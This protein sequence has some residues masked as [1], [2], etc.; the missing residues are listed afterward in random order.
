MSRFV[1]LNATAFV[2]TIAFTGTTLSQDV[3]NGCYHKTNGKLRIV[4]DPS[5]CKKKEIPI[6]WN[7]V[8]VQ[9]PKGDQ[10]DPGL[11]GPSG[12]QGPQGEQGP[13]GVQGPAGPSGNDGP[14]GTPGPPGQ[15]GDPGEPG[16]S[17]VGVLGVYDGN[18]IL[19]GYFVQ[20]S[21]RRALGYEVFDPS[22]PGFFTMRMTE[23]RPWP[24]ASSIGRF[25]YTSDNCDGQPHHYT[26][27]G[28]IE[29]GIHELLI[30]WAGEGF[31]VVDTS[32]QFPRLSDIK[33]Q[34]EGGT[35]ECVPTTTLVDPSS[36]VFP[37]KNI[38]RPQ[39]M[40]QTFSYPLII[41]P[42]D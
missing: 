11:E 6:V 7:Q 8:G 28:S 9:G 17:G 34:R 36:V 4:S 3:I 39:M 20:L 30:N 40:D 23:D 41:R 25:Y 15:K 42:M 21:S 2:F 14:P 1:L 5:L 37:L 10:G 16:P 29:F 19:V 33:A 35:Q 26:H 32:A 22:I 12:Q 27:P 31:F 13:Q 24:E 38:P 18:D